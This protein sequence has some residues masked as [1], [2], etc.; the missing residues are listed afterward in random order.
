MMSRLKQSSNLKKRQM[1]KLLFQK[2]LATL[3]NETNKANL[4]AVSKYSPVEDILT[5]VELG[6]LD[7]GENR[8][9]DLAEKTRALEKYE[10][11]GIRWHFIGHLQTN[12]I[13]ELLEIP[14]LWAIHSISS[15]KIIEELLKKEIL[16]KNKLNLFFQLNTSKEEEKDGF[17]S[18]QEIKES[19]DLILKYPDSK[20]KIFGL[21][22][23]GAI[24]TD[25]FLE[26]AEQSFKELKETRNFLNMPELKLSMGMSDD[27]K[28]AL[29]MGSDYIRVGS[30]LFKD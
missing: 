18:A 22:T 29:A 1:N 14:G 21:M 9:K 4:V 13:K 27:Y 3:K 10:P 16:L 15:K 23:M 11:L 5:A 30:Y 12:K 2:K 25:N 7:F 28:I 19:M 17:A 20:L 24:R 6:Q 8:V 26:S